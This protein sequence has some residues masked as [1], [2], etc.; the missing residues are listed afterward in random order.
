VNNDVNAITDGLRINKKRCKRTKKILIKRERKYKNSNSANTEYNKIREELSRY[1]VE[2]YDEAMMKGVDYVDDFCIYEN[3]ASINDEELEK[4]KKIDEQEEE[5]DMAVEDEDHGKGPNVDGVSEKLQNSNN[6]IIIL[7]NTNNILTNSRTTQSQIKEKKGRKVNSIRKIQQ[8]VYKVEQSNNNIIINLDEGNVDD[9]TNDK[10]KRFKNCFICKLSNLHLELKTISYYD[11][12]LTYFKYISERML[13]ENENIANNHVI[14]E[15]RKKLEELSNENKV[16][17]QNDTLQNPLSICIR[18]SYR[19][20]SD[21]NGLNKLFSSLYPKQKKPEENFNTSKN[22]QN[23]EFSFM[24]D[25]INEPNNYQNLAPILEELR[26]Q[27][28]LLERFTMFQK[29]LVIQIF[30][31]CDDYIT[32][33][34]QNFNK[35]EITINNLGSYYNML[36]L[37]NATTEMQNYQ[38]FKNLH[39]CISNLFKL[40]NVNVEVLKSHFCQFLGKYENS[41]GSAGGVNQMGLDSGYNYMVQN[42]TKL[43]GMNLPK[44]TIGGDGQQQYGVNNNIFGVIPGVGLGS[45][46]NGLG[47]SGGIN[48]MA[49][50]GEKD[51][52]QEDKIETK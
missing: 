23:N 26:G 14:F 37:D 11:E 19:L 45:T 20:M 35:M 40:F 51:S 21:K 17:P 38:T 13:K 2:E 12:L 27:I 8:R 29:F 30:Q 36:G 16:Q 6:N 15:N 39:L 4:Y 9:N 50:Q 32:N 5:A 28:L 43:S 44:Q 41:C 10:N 7:Q 3:E 25:K 24:N 1:I 33:S 47:N 18:C 52:Q 42:N 22:I 31:Q 48:N 34:Q 49:S 46:N